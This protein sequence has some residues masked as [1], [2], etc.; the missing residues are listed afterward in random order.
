MTCSVVYIAGAAYCG[1]TILDLL[2]NTSPY[3]AGVGEISQITDVGWFPNNPLNQSGCVCHRQVGN[4][5]C[6][7]IPISECPFPYGE[8]HSRVLERFKDFKPEVKAVVDSSKG[9]LWYPDHLRV[10]PLLMIKSPPKAIASFIK[11]SFGGEIP[12]PVQRLRPHMVKWVGKYE[13][14]VS[15]LSNQIVV[16]YDSMAS[17]SEYLRRV[18]HAVAQFIDVDEDLFYS[19][20]DFDTYYDFTEHHIHRFAGNWRTQREPRPVGVDSEWGKVWKEIEDS[21]SHS[22]PEDLHRMESLYQSLVKI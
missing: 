5:E 12:N 4:K 6:P 3:L 20:I 15:K 11:H 1:S 22:L 19:S 9:A 16:D 10:L 7:I 14:C 8:V 17:D 21:I 2:L 13:A 18:F